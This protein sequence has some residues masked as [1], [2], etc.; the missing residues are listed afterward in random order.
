MVSN[1][2]LQVWIFFVFL[3]IF[4]AIDVSIAQNVVSFYHK[5]FV[6][7]PVFN[8]K[9]W[10]ILK[11]MFT[12]QGFMLTSERIHHETAY[13]DGSKMFP[14]DY[15]LPLENDRRPIVMHSQSTN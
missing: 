5:S 4:N 8:A 9:V 11:V 3:I 6:I 13:L 7:I 14:V 1:K 15:L 12:I 2:R 10:L